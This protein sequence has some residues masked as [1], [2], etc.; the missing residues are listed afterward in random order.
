[1][2]RERTIKLNEEYIDQYVVVDVKR[3]ELAR[4]DGMT[5]RVKMIN[6]NGLAL[7]EFPETNGRARYDIELDYLK[8]VDKPEPKTPQAATEKPEQMRPES[9][10]EE[11]EKLSPLELAR[12]EKTAQEK[13]TSTQHSV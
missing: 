2:L 10:N 6:M 13:A 9:P 3:P 8:V 5:G 4:F 1:M 7:V 11:K 12:L